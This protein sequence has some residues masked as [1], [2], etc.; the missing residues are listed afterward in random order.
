M[1]AALVDPDPHAEPL[2][3]EVGVPL[4]S[5]L[6]E[7]L[8]RDLP[9]G[10]IIA[11]PNGMHL[12]QALAC[13]RA[14]IPVLVEKP[15]ATTVAD[16]LRLA[17][18][19]ETAGVPLLVGHHRRHSPVLAAARSVVAHGQL[20]EIVAVSATALFAK[21]LD[22]FEA[23]PWR[24]EPGG[25]PIMI[26]L[27]HDVDALRTLVGDV[28]RVHAAASN[29][30]RRSPVEDTAAVVMEFASGALGTLLLSDSAATPLS[31]E[32]TAHEDVAYP[33]YA[34]HD[35]YFVAGTRGSLGIP[36]LRLFTADGPPSWHRPLTTSTVAV[37]PADPLVRQLDH[38]CDVIAG[39]S[40]PLVGGRDAAESLRVTLAVAE[41]A[42]TGRAVECG[43][44][45]K[46]Q[47]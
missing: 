13:V 35:C 41:A 44:S 1:L 25:G 32:M 34:D 38:F 3:R 6:D 11:T 33:Y 2:A 46:P 42:H 26:N 22:Y 15:I 29:R 10:V 30:V 27:V 5:T 20:G 17:E 47:S 23:A 31:W 8:D 37:E 43:P 14:G 40:L 39:E 19:A 4:W 9:D 21:P 36:T 12:P 45:M 16:G 18:S 28:V 24:R 7:M